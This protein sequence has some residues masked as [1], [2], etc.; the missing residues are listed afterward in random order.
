MLWYGLLCYEMLWYDM[1]LRF[2]CIS[3][4][5]LLSPLLSP[6]PACSARCSLLAAVCPWEEGDRADATP[7]LSHFSAKSARHFISS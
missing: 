5:F 3:L 1:V 7:A 4:L 2:S 6:L